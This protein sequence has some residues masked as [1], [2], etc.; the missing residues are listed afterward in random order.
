MK[1]SVILASLFALCSTASFA[2]TPISACEAKRAHIEAQIV[3]AKAHGQ[4]QKVAG[5][6]K[7]LR[8]NI[9]HC[10]DVSLAKEQESKILS[11]KQKVADRETELREAELKGDAKKIVKSKAKLDEARQAL[12][13]AEKP[14]H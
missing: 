6:E 7:A 14:Q 10:S 12:S 3:E 13:E 9:A 2:A 1:N 5:L 11:A 4:Q 8:E